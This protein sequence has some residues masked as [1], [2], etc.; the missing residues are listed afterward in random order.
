V[1]QVDHVTCTDLHHQQIS[2][3]GQHVVLEPALV[4]LPVEATLP[5]LGG[6]ARTTKDV[7]L[8]MTGSPNGI[9]ATST[10]RGPR[11]LDVGQTMNTIIWTGPFRISALLRAC[12]DDD[13]PR[14][15]A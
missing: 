7:D 10:P 13:H 9:L 3:L 6:R 15:L 2:E 4:V 1:E 14:R 5:T 8:R 12:L 11:D